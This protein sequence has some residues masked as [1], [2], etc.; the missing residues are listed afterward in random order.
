[1][2][3]TLRLNDAIFREAKSEAAREGMTLTRFLEDAITERVRLGR[4]GKA[5]ARI[6]LPVFDSGVRLPATF[7]LHREARLADET[8][9]LAAAGVL[10]P[11]AAKTRHRR[12]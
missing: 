1:M 12:A 2:Q 3:T 5:A 11:P 7:D 4:Q 10:A 9:D 8:E 6:T